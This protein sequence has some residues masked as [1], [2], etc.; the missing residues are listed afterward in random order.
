MTC[1]FFDSEMRLEDTDIHFN[2]CK[3][4]YWICDNCSSY[5]VEKIRFGK[6]VSV[7]RSIG[8]Y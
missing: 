2:D 3:D 8:E 1:K 4:N 7:E 6:S 5:A